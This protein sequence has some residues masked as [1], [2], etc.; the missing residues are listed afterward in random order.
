ME[1]ACLPPPAIGSGK[2][3][4]VGDELTLLHGVHA[5]ASSLTRVNDVLTSSMV[6]RIAVAD[7]AI[8]AQVSMT[9]PFVHS[10]G[11]FQHGNILAA[12]TPS[13]V[14]MHSVTNVSA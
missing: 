11:T 4:A 10:P 6:V 2:F 9:C 5:G 1:S 3:V 14:G 13:L 7:H 8:K 12:L